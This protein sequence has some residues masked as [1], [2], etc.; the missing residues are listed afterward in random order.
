MKQLPS[1]CTPMHALG[2]DLL[3]NGELTQSWF[4]HSLS[5]LVRSH[6]QGHISQDL[7]VLYLVQ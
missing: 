2:F 7:P 1:H 4:P 3:V 5:P 6:R